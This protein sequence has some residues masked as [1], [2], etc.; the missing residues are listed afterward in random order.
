MLASRIPTATTNRRAPAHFP[1]HLWDCSLHQNPAVHLATKRNSEGRH[2]N[3][4]HQ[5]TRHWERSSHCHIQDPLR[6]C[7]HRH[8]SN[9]IRA[10]RPF[11]LQT[12]VQEISLQIF[13]PAK[14]PRIL[15]HIRTQEVPLWARLLPQ[16]LH[17]PLHRPRRTRFHDRLSQ[18]SAP[19]SRHR[20]P[21]YL[22]H[23]R[24]SQIHVHV[25]RFP[26]NDLC[27]LNLE[28]RIQEASTTRN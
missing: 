23:A 5:Y 24:H 16:H 13:T 26:T 12:R 18:N 27:F 28:T 11:L 8:H 22:T 3:L 17:H 20:G 14:G 6:L 1:V 7:R 10:R 15:F 4:C 9:I 2:G 25:L 21:R 19:H